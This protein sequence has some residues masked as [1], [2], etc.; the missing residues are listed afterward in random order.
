MQ[1]SPMLRRSVPFTT[2]ISGLG[3]NSATKP[4]IALSLK[5]P[6]LLSCEIPR[7]D[8]ATTY[9]LREKP[10]KGV[11]VSYLDLN[12]KSDVKVAPFQ[13]KRNEQKT[14]VSSNGCGGLV[15]AFNSS[16]S[17]GRYGSLGIVSTK[18]G[19]K[20]TSIDPHYFVRKFERG[21][22][23]SQVFT[24]LRKPDVVLRQ[25][26]GGHLF[27]THEAVVAVNRFG[28]LKTAYG[29]AYFDDSIRNVLNHAKQN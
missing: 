17:A 22:R 18:R 13:G 29:S 3:R 24:A 7:R 8:V 15:S 6:E 28:R 2:A 19:Y 10:A 14:Q 5:T 26:G 1:A 16:S 12:V 4:P 9:Q 21:V 23:S 20:I 27:I 11:K 25:P